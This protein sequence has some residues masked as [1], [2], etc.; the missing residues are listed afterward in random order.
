M[1]IEKIFL[2]KLLVMFR[3]EAAEHIEAMNSTIAEL[4][5]APVNHEEIIERI[6]REAHSLKGAARAVNMMQIASVCQT[7][8]DI[9]ADLK[10]GRTSA[11]PELY[12]RIQET[13]DAIASLLPEKVAPERHAK[14]SPE[15]LPVKAEVQSSHGFD[16]SSQESVRIS[17]ERLVNM[18]RRTEEL[19]S[20]KLSSRQR[21]KD[22][23]E[24]LA[25]ISEGGKL[26]S[27]MQSLLPALGKGGDSRF[28][29][30]GEYLDAE[31]RVGKALKA[32]I[33]AARK[34][35]EHDL[36]AN[37][38]MVD[39][40]LGDARGMLMM[41]FS[42]LADAFHRF[43]RELAR[44]QGKKI[45]LDVR[46]GE[47]E[48]D[49]RILE[50]MKDPLI[51]LLRN[52][53]DHGIERPEIRLAKG[54]PAEGKITIALTEQDGGK[55]EIAVSDDGAGIDIDKVKA[56]GSRM[57]LL[58]SDEIGKLAETEAISLVFK[59][60]VSTSPIITEIS[61]RGLGLTIVQ[62]KI[63]RLGG[64]VSVETGKDFGTIFRLSVPL[65]LATFRGI[66][67]R[68][69]D[70]AFALP[71]HH[72]E[73]VM[74]V[75][76]ENVFTLENRETVRLDGK[77]IPFARLSEV[78]ELDV[79]QTERDKVQAL[80]LGRGAGRIAF[81][82][83]EILGEQEVV[84]RTLGRQLERVRNVAGACVLGAG[85]V[86]PVL[87]AGDLMKSAVKRIGVRTTQA[88]E[89]REQDRAILV[90]EDSITSRTLLK[91]ILE[92]DGYRVKTAVDGIDALTALKS[93]D[94][95]LVVS[96]VD[97]PRMNGFDLTARIR[98]D[99]H[100][101]ELPVILVTALGSTE[102]RERGMEVGANAYIVKSSFDQSDLIDV[103][104]RLI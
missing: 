83:D 31:I 82:V 45:E 48:I 53:A 14:P 56:S 22:L 42:S 1:M 61:G 6:F 30:L 57:G 4:Q 19:L 52:A 26:R 16:G 23:N 40:L 103:V 17:V 11:S 7:L 35:A 43:M 100:L 76:R 24:I 80:I 25:L 36:R 39:E 18:M 29:R 88:E 77:A 93:E 13:I 58:A 5:A 70:H 15:A 75:A 60:G 81:G 62:E 72:V 34:S 68:A 98:A 85:E 67:V 3:E 104:G 69:G 21:L 65:S 86:V 2:D 46:R 73:R 44:E 99:K 41:P 79:R 94:F 63:E 20:T 101:S 59:S 92:S 37:S 55:V 64:S 89:V 8:E 50:E 54:K 95:D 84:V 90:V 51:H 47:V 49:R 71:L 27:E 87:N 91:G 97:M 38:A 74:R 33:G 9:F 102:H 32:R 66:L 78:L 28:D 96:D 12:D 10:S